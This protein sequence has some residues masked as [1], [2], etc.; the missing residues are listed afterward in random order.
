MR[1]PVPLF[2][3]APR[4]ESSL[5]VILLLAGLV[6]IGFGLSA[7]RAVIVPLLLASCLVLAVQPLVDA[8]E[9]R[10]VKPQLAIV[11]GML[12]LLLGIG[13]FFLTLA[14]GLS[15]LLAA[16]PQYEAAAKDFQRGAVQWLHSRGLVRAAIAVQTTQIG[17]FVITHSAEILAS[18]PGAVSLAVFVM[19]LTLFMLIERN[20]MK[21]R[22][23]SNLSRF[24]D[25]NAHILGDVQRY[26]GT[27]TLLSIATGALVFLLCLTC[28]IPNAPL[29]GVVAFVCNYI[30]VAGTLI[31]ATPPLLLSLLA[32]DVTVVIGLLVGFAAIKGI[33]GNLLEPK[34]LGDSC[35]LS[36]LA[37]VVSIVV[38]G[39]LLGPTGALLSVPLTSAFRVAMSHVRDLRW[40]NLLLTPAESPE[41]APVSRQAPKPP[42]VSSPTP[43]APPPGTVS[44]T[45]P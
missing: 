20:S 8:L 36:P 7:S 3:R 11:A 44:S 2:S 23:R 9:R 14:Y 19:L 10:N 34:M 12:A 5:R 6:I 1:T 4:L 39:A 21:T 32:R 16:L 22:L 17:A 40:L 25:E 42:T 15:E 43:P 13:L 28:E 26:L 33:I 29:W 35:G 41:V 18:L 30:P 45:V 24:A 27:K 31:S 38:W 37:V